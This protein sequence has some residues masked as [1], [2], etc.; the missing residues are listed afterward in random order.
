MNHTAPIIGK[1]AGHIRP[2]H[3]WQQRVFVIWP[4]YRVLYSKNKVKDKMILYPALEFFCNRTITQRT[5][6]KVR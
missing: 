1:T 6:I 3:Y 4:F 5:G 2:A